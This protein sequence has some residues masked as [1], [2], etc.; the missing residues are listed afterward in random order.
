MSKALGLKK[1]KF[2]GEWWA[3]QNEQICDIYSYLHVVSDML[4][5][6]GL[7]IQCGGIKKHTKNNSRIDFGKW[8]IVR[9]SSRGRN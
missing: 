4:V 5:Y 3:L 1:Y 9:I 8:P 2:N 7:D 6:S